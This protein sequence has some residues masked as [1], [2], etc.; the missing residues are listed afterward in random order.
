MSLLLFF[1]I[2]FGWI[3]V[4]RGDIC[5][6]GWLLHQIVILDRCSTVIRGSNGNIDSMESQYSIC[7]GN[8]INT[9]LWNNNDCLGQ[10]YLAFDST[11]DANTDCNNYVECYGA[12]LLTY[13]NSQ[14]C[15]QG[16]NIEYRNLTAWFAFYSD[17]NNCSILGLGYTTCVGSDISVV[18]VNSEGML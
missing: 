8:T 13:V 6:Y 3:E 12:S 14:N 1:I 15:N 4:L 2:Y 7:N 11:V 16:I 9:Q 17:I 18:L 10:P 5:Q